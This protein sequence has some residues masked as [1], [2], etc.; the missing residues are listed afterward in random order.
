MLP[1]IAQVVVCV[2]LVGCGFSA[3]PA[4]TTG[5]TVDAASPGG[6]SDVGSG[7]DA[8]RGS[9]S[10]AGVATKTCMQVWMDGTVQLG[11][12]APLTNQSNSDVI[13][14]DP[15][16]S[17][18]GK[19]LYYATDRITGPGTSDIA[20]ATRPNTQAAFGTGAVDVNLSTGTNDE[21][22]PS[23]TLDEKIIVI[24]SNRSGGGSP[25]GQF[26]ILYNA[27]GTPNMFGTPDMNHMSTVDQTQ[28]DH[29]DP[30]LSPDGLRL[31]FAPVIAGQRI[32]LASRGQ[33]NDDFSGAAA[34]PIINGANGSHDADPAL[35][36]DE[37]I[38]LFTSDRGGN[39]DLYFATRPDK[40]QQFS[41]PKP[42]PGVNGT[43]LDGDPFLS[44]DG[45]TLY[46]A[47]NR[48]TGN[49]NYDLFSATVTNGVP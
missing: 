29:F 8:G 22:R 24:A 37:K 7:S 20:V 35:S 41:S 48:L 18:D 19:R 43:S 36:A 30:F 39:N 17:M 38:I 27:T 15:W 3:K 34:V 26:N 6:G 25:N 21:S 49:L 11:T 42:V 44:F 1:R 33:L 46:F 40:A 2:G 47:S 4:D 9:G 5:G 28:V 16:V 32:Y 31:Y 12:P 23:L 45:C 10:D 14:R 13:E